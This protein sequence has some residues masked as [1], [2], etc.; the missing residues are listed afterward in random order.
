MVFK[1]TEM[2][3]DSKPICNKINLKGGKLGVFVFSQEAVIWSDL[4]TECIPGTYS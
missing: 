1:G 2:L 4:K 3:I